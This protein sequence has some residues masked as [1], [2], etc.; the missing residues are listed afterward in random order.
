VLQRIKDGQDGFGF[1]SFIPFFFFLSLFTFII[2][3][4]GTSQVNLPTRFFSLFFH[5][6]D[7][8][9]YTLKQLEIG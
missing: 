2:D 7:T 5:L 3:R 9:V 4:E 8:F 1:A 6:S